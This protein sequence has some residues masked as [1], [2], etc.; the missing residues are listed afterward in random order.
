MNIKR[1]II[2]SLEK[3]KKDGIEVIENVP[4]RVRINYDGDRLDLSSGFR[5]DVSK[6]DDKKQRVKIGTTNKIKQ[7]ANEINASLLKIESVIQ[8]IFKSYEIEGAVPS[9]STLRN[10]INDKIKPKNENSPEAT[11]Q[12]KFF[13]Y[14][15]QF[16]QENRK[17]NNWTEGTQK[18]LR[19][20]RNHLHDF[21]P[22][23]AVND[24]DNTTLDKY[25]D[26]LLKRRGFKNST[27]EK[28]LKFLKWFL[29]WGYREGGGRIQHSFRTVRKLRK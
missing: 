12:S 11:I 10:E 26:F 8:D 14:Y 7:S 16:I 19:T 18:K 25:M 15:D 20:V 27:L 21:K 23:I 22:N 3:R 13:D 28:H 29:R 5:V 1:N 24:F 6:W 4:I 2:F 17:L 9:K